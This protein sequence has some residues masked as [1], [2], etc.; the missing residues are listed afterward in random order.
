MVDARPVRPRAIVEILSQPSIS[1]HDTLA[2]GLGLLVEHV[3][4]LQM[5][6]AS[7]STAGELR[8]KAILESVMGEEAAKVLILLDAVRGGWMD[9]LAAKRSLGYFSSHFARGIYQRVASINPGTFREVRN[10]VQGLRPEFYLDGPNDS[11]W[12]FRNE[13]E[14]A[15]ELAFYVDY[16]KDEED[17]SWVTPSNNSYPSTHWPAEITTRLVLA[18]H[19]TGLLTKEG[20]DI[21]AEQWRAVTVSD[22][23]SFADHFKHTSAMTNELIE[24]ELFLPTV[25]Q[26][27]F[28][29]VAEHWP[30]PLNS[31][32]IDKIKVTGEELETERTRLEEAF[33]RSELGPIEY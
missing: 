16:V 20:L 1:R 24:R 13:I 15:R 11:D 30:F 17:Y 27:D 18:M 9:Q 14:S 26:A 33:W 21:T 6:V 3:E 32:A 8:G 7:W 25:V 19:R 31:I 5:T 28:Q 12:I 23:T 22:E 29:Q 2:H 10:Y 4:A